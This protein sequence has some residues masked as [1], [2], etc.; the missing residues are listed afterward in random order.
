[1]IRN[2]I[3]EKI[4]EVGEFEEYKEIDE[5][6][7]SVREK[8]NVQCECYSAG[9]FESPGYDIDCFIIAFIDENGKLQGIDVQIERY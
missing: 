8:F 3:L 5:I 4:N 7:E 1:M 9:G 6:V 2:Y